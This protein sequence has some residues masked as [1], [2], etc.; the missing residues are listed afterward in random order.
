M[1]HQNVWHVLVALWSCTLDQ[2]CFCF[3]VV[4]LEN[5]LL[6]GVPFE[7]SDEV[8]SEDFVLPIGKA[9]IEREGELVCRNTRCMVSYTL[10]IRKDRLIFLVA[11]NPF[12][13]FKS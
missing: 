6:Y 8:L 11:L 4:F 7:I 3:S 10:K 12:R 9:K 1:Q 13:L 5:E 2:S